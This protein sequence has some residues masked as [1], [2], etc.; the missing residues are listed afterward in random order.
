MPG[1][2]TSGSAPAAR[3]RA[4]ALTISGLVVVLLLVAA[5]ILS[6]TRGGGNNG[7]EGGTAGDSPTTGEEAS[8]P[9]DSTDV[10]E[11]AS[12]EPPAPLDV[13]GPATGPIDD[14]DAEQARVEESVGLVVEATNELTE[15]GDGAIDGLEAIATGFVLG[16]LENL[17]REYAEQGY[18]QSGEAR[19]VSSEL[20]SAD[21]DADPPHIVI[22][23]CIDV[24]AITLTDAAGND[25]SDLLYNPGH[26]V[27]HEYGADFVDDVWK[28]STHEI[29]E[30]QDCPSPEEA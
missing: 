28:V 19:I 4:R 3:S 15:R 21:L 16:E 11:D 10:P 18:T 17:S 12:T 2:S 25:V 1:E 24:S 9:V 6:Q 22:D 8:A 13:D 30:T 7:A 23:V 20:V 29:P 26:P 5:L 27:R 14:I